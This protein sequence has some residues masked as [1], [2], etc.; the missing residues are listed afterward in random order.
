MLTKYLKPFVFFIPA[1][2]NIHTGS[3]SNWQWLLHQETHLQS[4][5]G[6]KNLVYL[7]FTVDCYIRPYWNQY[8]R[9]ARWTLHFNEGQRFF[10]L[11]SVPQG[12]S[13]VV[14]VFC[15]H[16]DSVHMSKVARMICPSK[17]TS[18]MF[19]SPPNGLFTLV[20]SCL[21]LR[22]DTDLLYISMW[23]AN[24]RHAY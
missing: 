18:H 20:G 19:Q 15:E 1:A 13:D 5:K 3:N 23:M 8:A 16:R 17:S 14:S 12:P 24:V 2:G 7:W 10:N 4:S 21:R 6:P 9:A 11:Y 22:S